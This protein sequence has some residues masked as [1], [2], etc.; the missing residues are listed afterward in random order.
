MPPTPPHISNRSASLTPPSAPAPSTQPCLK[1]SPHNASQPRRATEIDE[2]CANA[3]RT[4]WSDNGLIVIHSDFTKSEPGATEPK[5]NLVICNPPY[6]RHHHLNPAQKE[7]L[8][9][10]L[11]RQGTVALSGL[12]GLYAYFMALTH[13]WM[14]RGALA[15]WL[16]PSEFMDVN[17]GAGIREYLT[18]QVSLHQI[19]RYDPENSQFDDALV[20]SAVVWFTNEPPAQDQQ[21]RMTFGGSLD[22]PMEEQEVTLDLL[23]N[24]H[25]W[26]KYPGATPARREDEPTLGDLFRIKRG[27]AT[28]N[29]GFF[30][31]PEETTQRLELPPWALKPILPGPRSLNCN[32]VQA[33]EDCSPDIPNRLYLLDSALDE[34]AIAEA[35]EPMAQY[36]Q[37]GHER[38]VPGGYLCKKRTPWYSQEQRPPAPFL[39]TYLGRIKKNEARPFRFIANDSTA[40]AHNVYLM[41]YPK[42]DLARRLE[43]DPALKQPVWNALNQIDPR[44][45]I[46]EGRVYGGGLRKWEPKEMGRLPAQAIVALYQ[47]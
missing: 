8:T 6:V 27:I 9:D 18:T 5:F 42:G 22:Q 19:H 34:T 20:S 28:G 33:R 24:D 45:M 21:V 29:N 44:H 17:Y 11:Q 13:P 15:G 1:P 41:M 39:S 30:I 35:S 31:I 47:Q 32:H 25:K 23:R 16:V 37:A 38:G 36:L 43:G 4:I 40:V 2:Q 14:E 12:A 26:S 7:Y 3:A 46:E 10:K